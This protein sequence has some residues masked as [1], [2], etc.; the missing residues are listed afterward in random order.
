M[1]S[2]KLI[3]HYKSNYI[4]VDHVQ[5]AWHLQNRKVKLSGI[6]AVSTCRRPDAFLLLNKL[7]KHCTMTIFLMVLPACSHSK[8]YHCC[9]S[10]FY[11]PDAQQHK[12]NKHS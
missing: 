1:L 9:G 2:F 6:L 5:N 12:S 4:F 3:N 7:S 8:P 11:S 10:A